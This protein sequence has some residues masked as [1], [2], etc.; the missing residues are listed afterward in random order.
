[1]L[2]K[3]AQIKLYIIPKYY[4]KKKIA[5]NGQ[6]NMNMNDNEA[7]IKVNTKICSLALGI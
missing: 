5:K 1:M 2:I 6:I 4:R 7:T 3:W